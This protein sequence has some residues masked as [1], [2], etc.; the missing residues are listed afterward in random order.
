[1]TPDQI[2][3]TIVSAYH[4]LDLAGVLIMGVIGGT[5]ARQHGFDIVGYLFIAMVSAL[6]GGMLRDVLINEGTV[7]AMNQ[8]EYLILAFTGALIAQFTYFSGHTWEIVRSHGDG[9]ISA[10][11]ASVGAFKA[12]A[13]GLPVLPTIMMGVLTATGGSMIRDVLIGRVPAVFGDNQPSVVPAITGAVITLIGANT[14]HMDIGAVLGP[15]ASFALFM[16]AYWRGWRV[17][18]SPD[19]APVNATV[20]RVA[21]TARSRA[22][23]GKPSHVATPGPGSSDGTRDAHENNA[24]R[25]ELLDSVPKDDAFV[26][27]LT[28]RLAQRLEDGPAS[29]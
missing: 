4:S 24:A 6:G 26:D 21:Q 3:P 18:T 17:P 5:I 9:L 16:V 28:R 14:G 15:V 7:A 12:I 29:R 8:P 22:R 20:S 23:K 19:F 25:Q 13:Y 2:E 10:L 1:M 27:E 11:W